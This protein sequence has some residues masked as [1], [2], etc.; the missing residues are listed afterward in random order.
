VNLLLFNSVELD[1][2]GRLTVT[3]RRLQHLLGVLRSCA[4]DRIR[5]GQIDGQIG[6]GLVET[7][8]QNAARIAIHLQQAPPAALPLTVVLALP[9]PKML[10]RILRTVAE[11]GVKDIYLIN[12]YRVEKSYWMSPL[13]QPAALREALLAGLEQAGDTRLP[14]LRTE[15]RFRPFAEDRLPALCRD[16]VAILAEPTAAAPYPPTPQTPAL[17]AIGPEGGFIPFERELLERAGCAPHS[18]GT[19]ILR[20]ETALH[21]ALGRHLSGARI[22]IS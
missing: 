12:S 4:G 2:T 18:L 11:V 1:P 16:S 9:R 17:L 15:P 3:D 10:R 22:A 5:V 8:D 14:E 20:V 6:E 13:L 21:C 7:I 19:R